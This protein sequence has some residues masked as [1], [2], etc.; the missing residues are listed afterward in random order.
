MELYKKNLKEKGNWSN[1][2]FTFIGVQ[3][4]NKKNKFKE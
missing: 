2:E 3:K 4:T 1:F